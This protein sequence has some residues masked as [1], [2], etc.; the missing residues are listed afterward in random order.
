[1]KRLIICCDGTWNTPD[2]IDEGV[3]TPTNVVRI[4]NAIDDTLKVNE[5]DQVKYYHPGVGSEELLLKK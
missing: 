2:Q 1:M 3:I 4:Y 5:I